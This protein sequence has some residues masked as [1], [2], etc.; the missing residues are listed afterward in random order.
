MTLIVSKIVD[1]KI[2]VHA[3]SM[4][5]FQE[6]NG[7]LREGDKMSESMLKIII[8]NSKTCVYYA[9][10]VEY[11]NAAIKEIFDISETNESK[12]IDI[13]KKFSFESDKKTTFGIASISKENKVSQKRR[14]RVERLR[15]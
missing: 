14:I 11:A 5:T 10:D 3:D 4:I 13:L 15:R 1:G 9:G 8:I 12:I 6:K 2:K 7:T